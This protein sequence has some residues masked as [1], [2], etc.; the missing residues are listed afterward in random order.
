M[1]ESERTRRLPPGLVLRDNRSVLTY[2]D[3]PSL[4]QP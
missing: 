3:T 2:G 4:V 1:R